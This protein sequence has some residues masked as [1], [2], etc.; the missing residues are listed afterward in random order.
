MFTDINIY[1]INNKTD[2]IFEKYICFIGKEVK[3]KL[4]KRP[5][6]MFILI[7]RNIET[8]QEAVRLVGLSATLPNYQVNCLKVNQIHL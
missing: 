3:Q 2:H 8:T 1:P 4:K 5:N 6:N 7:S